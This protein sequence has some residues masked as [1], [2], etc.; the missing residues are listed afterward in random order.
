[1]RWSVGEL[2]AGLLKGVADRLAGGAAE[3]RDR[4]ARPRPESA[5]PLLVRLAHNPLFVTL[6]TN[7]LPCKSA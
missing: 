6:S 7:V 5:L 4:V 1:M 3:A 2:D